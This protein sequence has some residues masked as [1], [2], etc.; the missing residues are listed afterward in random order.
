MITGSR[1]EDIVRR[2][3]CLI[4]INY[5]ATLQLRRKPL[6]SISRLLARQV[7]WKKADGLQYT[8][9]VHVELLGRRHGSRIPESLFDLVI[10]FRSNFVHRG[11]LFAML[12]AVRLEIR[13]R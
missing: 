2:T 5:V 8:L 6:Q 3:G 7:V 10:T 1:R 12:A 9:I 13:C 4:V 11:H